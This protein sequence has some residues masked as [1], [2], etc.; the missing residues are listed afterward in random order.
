MRITGGWAKTVKLAVAAGIT[1]VVSA[2][3]LLGS[4]APAN[5]SAYHGFDASC[6]YNH[7]VQVEAIDL[8]SY[9]GWSANWYP[10]LF[11]WTGTGWSAYLNGRIQTQAASG[12]WNMAGALITSWTF[13]GLPTNY[14]KVRVTYSYFYNGVLQGTYP[15][16][17]V[18]H[19]RNPSDPYNNL[20]AG[21]TTSAYC[22]EG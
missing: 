4:A 21:Y 12:S 3:M 16:M 15:N 6:G 2:V 17:D 9:P 14:Y 7:S 18:T 1:S 13:T 11:R 19:Y 10:T 8:S 22:Y 5:A 20:V